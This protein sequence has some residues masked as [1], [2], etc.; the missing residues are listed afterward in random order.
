MT[1]VADA[2]AWYVA[3]R[4]SLFRIRRIAE[5]HWTE[6]PWDAQSQFGRDD[7]LRVLEKDGIVEAAN[8]GLQHFDDIAVL[9]LFSMFEAEVRRRVLAEIQV[10]VDSVRHPALRFSTAEAQRAIEEGSF[11]QVLE[12]YKPI[13]LAGLVE[14][15]NQV[16]RY[17]NWVAHGRRA[18]K[19]PEVN[20]K[21]AFDRLTRFLDAMSQVP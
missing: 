9:V 2:W 13:G 15:V 10:E 6:L 3:T 19:P 14:E 4:D 5:K 12:P 8:L 18:T 17:R 16:R 11:F 1:S 7:K 21:S 20:P